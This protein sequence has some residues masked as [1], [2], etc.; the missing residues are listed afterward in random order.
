MNNGSITAI[1]MF[2]GGLDSLLAT[3]LL[4]EQ[5]LRVQAIKF[6]TPFF[7]YELLR[8]KEGFRHQMKEKYGIEACVRDVS[9]K[10][11]EMLRKPSHG[12][13]KNFNPCVDCKILLISEAR[14]L[15]AEF[16]ASFLATGEVL[17]Q[18]PMSQRQD[19]LRVIERDSGCDGLLLRPLCAKKLKPTKP[20]LE[21]LVDRERLLAFSGRSRRP[22]MELAARF[23]IKDYASPAG[24]CMLTDPIL[25][26]RIKRFYEEQPRFKPMDIKLLLAGRSFRLPHGGLL[27]MGRDERENEEIEELAQPEDWTLNPAADW[28]GPTALL[29]FSDHPE[30]LQLAAGLV[31]RHSKKKPDGTAD[32]PVKT[33]KG[34]H[35]LEL[36]GVPPT[37]DARMAWVR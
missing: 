1:T 6:V 4:M 7:G 29:R 35:F 28:P 33:S 27:A 26:S 10:Y 25:A 14:R 21:G 5:G 19:S 23:G 8:D 36:P 32:M 2:S 11:L 3:R 22:Q 24:G 9:E 37:E 12:Y 31:A 20:E 17:G 30:D 13:G 34:N 16:G 15:L 18:R